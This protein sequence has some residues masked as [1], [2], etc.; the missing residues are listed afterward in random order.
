MLFAAAGYEVC[1]YD[2]EPKQ[3]SSALDNILLQLRD[4]DKAGLLRG[5]LSVEQQHQRIRGTN[6]F[7]ECVKG[8]KYVQVSAQ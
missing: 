6:D 1:M 8:A 7:E 3:V 2:I 5:T 4:L